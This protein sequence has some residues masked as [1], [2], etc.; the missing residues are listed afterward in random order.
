MHHRFFRTVGYLLKDAVD[1]LWLQ[2]ARGD[3]DP[4]RSHNTNCRRKLC[5]VGFFVDTVHQRRRG[6]GAPHLLQPFQVLGD[7]LVGSQHTLFNQRRCIG[8]CLHHGANGHL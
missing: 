3:G 5:L 8:A 2:L 7:G 1:L 6:T 4:Q